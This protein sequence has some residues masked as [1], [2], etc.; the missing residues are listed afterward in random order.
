MRSCVRPG[1]RVALIVSDMSRFW[2]RQD[3]IV[4]HLVDYLL[5][6]CALPPEALTI[7]IANGTHPGGDEK[8]LRTLVTNGVFDRVR[9]VNH[10][11]QADDLVCL[12]TTSFGTEVAVNPIAAQ[13]DLCVCLGAATYHVMAGFGGGRKSI[14]PGISSEATIRQNH[15][16]SLDP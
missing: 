6:D 14:L 7:V 2:M 5:D 13:A 15:A 16:L 1:D 9:V 3:L 10:D 8:T 12:G 4:P 11:C